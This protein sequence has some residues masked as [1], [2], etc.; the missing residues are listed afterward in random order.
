MEALVVLLFAIVFSGWA[1]WVSLR[2]RNKDH[3]LK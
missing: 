1:M 3:E 2:V